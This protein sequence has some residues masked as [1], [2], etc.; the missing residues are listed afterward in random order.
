MAGWLISWSRDDSP[1]DM[2]RWASSSEA[3][4]RYGGTMVELRLGR[5]ALGAWR[6]SQGEFPM[7]GSIVSTPGAHV[8]WIGQ[9]V[10]DAGDAT[11]EAVERVAAGSFRDAEV[12]RLNG[13]FAAA[14]VREGAREVRVVTDRHR[15]YPVYLHRGARVFVASTEIRCVAPWLAHADL[16]PEAVDMLL[17]CGELI[18]RQTLLSGVEMISPGSVLCDAGAGLTERRY[19]SMRSE[20]RAS[21]AATAEDLG[22]KLK[23]GVRRLEA[24]TPRPGITLSGGLDSRIILDLCRRPEHV[25]SFTWGL[26]GCRDIAYA[27]EFANLVKSPHVVRHWEPDAFTA[28]WS[29][30]VDLTGGSCGIESMFMLPFVPLLASSCDVVLNGLAGDVILG[31]NW[32][33]RAWIEERDIRRLGQNVWRWR[34]TE[35]EDRLVDRLVP[36]ALR[37]AS[38]SDRWAESIASREGGQPIERL[39]DWLIENRIFRTTNCG[40][41][42]LRGGVE[43]HSPF[44][45]RDFIDSLSH[46]QQ[47][48]KLK[49][50]LY[51]RVMNRVAP[52][53]AS[54]AWQRTSLVPAR[55]YY[56]NLAA[57][58]AQSLLIRAARPFG[59]EPFSRLK[60]ADTSAWMRGPWRQAIDEALLS[61][62]LSGLGFLDK[63]VVR[64][65]WSE[66]LAGADHSRQISVLVAIELFARILTNREAA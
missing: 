1:L 55:G 18:D 65:I 59:V 24:V 57:M 11:V 6:R 37:P 52:R 54:I 2:H 43:S 12:S 51:L 8:A 14:V 7:S 41:M 10:E 28:L 30:G 53:S 29:R 38:A 45:D 27:T 56:A 23:A 58:A 46:A 36:E 48:H 33:K 20:G 39:N 15:H 22:A 63:D 66:H 19:W 3:A 64:E 25:P 49:H 40:T 35:K 60:V 13:P 32:L 61:G 47:A 16:D 34:V 5:V 31:G 50:R 42:L 4:T 21:L 26:P 9:C 44:F 17:R 62:H